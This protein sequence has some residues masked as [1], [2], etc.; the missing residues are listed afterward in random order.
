MPIKM[1]LLLPHRVRACP[2]C[3]REGIR[4]QPAVCA[5]DKVVGQEYPNVRVMCVEDDMAV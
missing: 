1:V 5:A 3:N 4:S 2:Q